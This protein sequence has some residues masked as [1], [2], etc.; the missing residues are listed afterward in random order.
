M[1]DFTLHVCAL[2][3]IDENKGQCIVPDELYDPRLTNVYGDAVHQEVVQ[4]LLP[5]GGRVS[6]LLSILL[7]NTHRAAG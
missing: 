7:L 3:F 2:V 1:F 5:H 6:V 4:G